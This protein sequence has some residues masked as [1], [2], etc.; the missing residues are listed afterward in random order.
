MD[1]RNAELEKQHAADRLAL[2]QQIEQ[3]ENEF[4]NSKLTR[5]E[6]EVNAVREKYF[7]LIEQAILFGEDTAI[8]EE[9][10]QQ[11]IFDIRQ[12]FRQEEKDAKDKQDEIDEKRK[13]EAVKKAKASAQELFTAAQNLAKQVSAKELKRANEKVARG[14]KLTKAEIKR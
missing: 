4:L 8:L 5:E 6:Q 9:A 3:A 11:T 13:E 2:L 12:K 10:Q 1:R 14:E 7:F